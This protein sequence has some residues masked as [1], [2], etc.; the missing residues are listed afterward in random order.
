VNVA[1]HALNALLVWRLC[2]LLRIPGAWFVA[3]LFALH[4]VQVESVA[5]I[6]ERKNLL[7]GCFY[8]LAALAYLRFLAPPSTG[9]PAR[10]GLWYAAALLLFLAALLSKSVTCSL[11]VALILMLLWQRR[12][13][14]S[15]LLLP[16]VPLLAVGLALALHTV[17]LERAH[18]GATGPEFDFSL[19]ERGL[20]AGRALLFYPQKLVAPWPLIFIYPRWALDASRLASYW[21]FAVVLVVAVAALAACRRGIRG[22][23]L[24]LAYFVA[25]I[26]PALGFFD[27]YPMRYSFVADHFQY[28]ACL[29]LF[30]LGVGTIATLARQRPAASVAG[31]V[32]LAALGTLS[33]CQ[34]RLYADAETLWRATVARNPGAW[35]AHNNLAE[36]VSAR[37]AHDEALVL[38]RQGLASAT[39]EPAADQLRFNL[40]LTLGRAG[41]ELEALP[42]YEQLQRSEG[43]MEVRLGQTLLRLGRHDEAI[44]WLESAVAAHPDDADARMFLADACSAAGRGADAIAAGERALE[45]A[46][47][48]GR[49]DLAARIDQRLAR[50]RAAAPPS[51]Q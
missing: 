25:T 14:T 27:V 5:W 11:P 9:R 12:R 39:S 42:L 1:L 3:A 45:L 31:A 28:L 16:L 30:A 38:L 29:G 33:W 6:T 8:L 34:C 4:P 44:V 49:A 36:L 43:G 2:R 23:A 13:L 21:P 18:V 10:P 41:R 40:A 48:Q 17:H 50:W 51:R 37:G 32:L 47:L 35:I 22:P 15:R 19:A 46:R 26:F 20:I 7:S 24:A